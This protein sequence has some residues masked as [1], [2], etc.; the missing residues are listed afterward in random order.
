M[1]PESTISASQAAASQ[2]LFRG[3]AQSQSQPLYTNEGRG[4]MIG[5]VCIVYD[6][7]SGR[8][9]GGA[10]FIVKCLLTWVETTEIFLFFLKG[11]FLTDVIHI[12]MYDIKS[13]SIYTVQFFALLSSLN[14]NSSWLPPCQCSPSKNSHL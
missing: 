7:A 4:V 5:A 10:L 9:R 8:L 1:P 13:F 12:N 6:F 3:K 2:M 11:I 14:E